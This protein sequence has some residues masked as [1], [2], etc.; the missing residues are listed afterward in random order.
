MVRHRLSHSLQ[1]LR[2]LGTPRDF[3]AGVL[4]TLGY[5]G[6]M[7]VSCISSAVACSGIDSVEGIAAKALAC[8][9]N[10]LR[11]TPMSYAGY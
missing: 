6:G 5:A 4:G 1:T 11:D 9:M 7:C 3:D 10:G 8:T 2:H